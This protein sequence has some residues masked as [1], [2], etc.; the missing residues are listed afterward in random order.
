M[1]VKTGAAD[2]ATPEK[3]RVKKMNFFR[4]LDE[5]KI[6]FRCKLNCIF[7]TEIYCA[8]KNS[9]AKIIQYP[10]SFLMDVFGLRSTFS[11]ELILLL[12]SKAWAPN[13]NNNDNNKSTENLQINELKL[14][15]EMKVTGN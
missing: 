8:T 10:H 11:S 6:L 5:Q 2:P 4:F 14:N 13:N 15:E 1:A 7:Q 12:I 3:K 9:F